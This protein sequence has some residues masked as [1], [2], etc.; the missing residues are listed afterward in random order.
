MGREFHPG[1]EIDFINL[2]K[3]Q[4]SLCSL[5]AQAWVSLVRDL[6]EDTFPAEGSLSRLLLEHASM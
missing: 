3:Q 4:Q 6:R 1:C 2:N 5:C